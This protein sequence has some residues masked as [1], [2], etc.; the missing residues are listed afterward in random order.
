[1]T[2]LVV[3]NIVVNHE[4]LCFYQV[5]C[6]QSG[7]RSCMVGSRESWNLQEA[8]SNPRRNSSDEESPLQHFLLMDG[9]KSDALKPDNSSSME[10]HAIELTQGLNNL[11]L[12]AK[13]KKVSL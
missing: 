13:T 10:S 11:N 12:G 4:R 3:I 5:R 6:T 2:M 1:M 7:K 8:G 9:S